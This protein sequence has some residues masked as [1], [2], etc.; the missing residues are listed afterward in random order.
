MIGL[1]IST[2]YNHRIPKQKFYDNLAVSPA[3]KK[4]FIDQI[5]MIY[6]RNKISPT[7]LNI[8]AGEMVV[9]IEIIEIQLTS[10]TL[11]EAVL[12]QIDK[13][14]P[15]H[16]VF[17]LEFDGKHQAWA[18]YKEAVIGGKNPFRVD[19]YYHT[20]WLIEDDIPLDNM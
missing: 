20:D 6:W 4:F 15:Y 3:L 8:A 11:N 12:R 10:P 14:I 5:K 13:E 17:L 1:P 16:I 2:E 18:S 7:T 19:C 9:E